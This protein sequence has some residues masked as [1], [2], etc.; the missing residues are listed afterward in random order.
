VAVLLS[1]VLR[2]VR[3]YKSLIPVCKT[4]FLNSP[5]S[6]SSKIFETQSDVTYSAFRHSAD[7]TSHGG[8]VINKASINAKRMRYPIYGRQVD[9]PAWIAPMFEARFSRAVVCT[10]CLSRLFLYP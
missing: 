8:N 7:S 9:I 10:F 1:L 2:L 6:V 4:P 3:R 5:Y